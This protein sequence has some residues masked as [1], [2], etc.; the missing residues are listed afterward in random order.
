M[1]EMMLV[2]PPAFFCIALV[3]S[4]LGMGGSQ[5]YVPVLF[6]L[7]MD[8]KA[9]AIPLGLLLNVVNSS[10]AAV[11][12]TRH[13]LVNWRVALP[14]AITMLVLPPLG[15]MVN[16]RL[17]VG[18]IILLFALF[19]ATAA[20]LMLV[21]W[22]PKSRGMSR[23]G[24]T[25]V[26]TVGGGVLGFLV[27]LVGRGGGSFVVPLLYMCGLEAKAAAATSAVVVTGSA[28]SGFLAHLPTADLHWGLTL[29]TALGV[30]AGSQ[31][32]SR[33]MAR[34]LK[35]RALRVVFGVVLLGVAA[36]LLLQGTLGR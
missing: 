12:Y 23:R 29:A 5:L 2:A 16:T 13:R 10:S 11:T 21:G 35:S 26:G 27:G 18:P 20:V 14:F 31:V 28:F 17:A 9:E 36:A 7:G 15:A 3:F 25:V 1:Y 24:Q 34:K 4:M 30:L 33:L 6:W 32:G 22:R 19:T 8:F